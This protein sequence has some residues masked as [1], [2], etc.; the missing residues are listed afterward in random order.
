MAEDKP[1]PNV[2]AKR[3]GINTYTVRSAGDAELR[4]GSPGEEGVFS[5]VELLQAAIAGCA[6]M[7]AEPQ[8]T[9]QLGKDFAATTTV[10]AVQDPED[11]RLDKLIT[12]ISTDMAGLD[13]E[14][15]D[16]LISRSEKFIEKLC[17]VKRTLQHGVE[18]ETS[19]R[20]GH[21]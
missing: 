2:T 14:K 18:T 10:E 20:D 1:I 8:L 16:K 5:P 11:N 9:S 6:A 21:S 13:P 17:T 4:I 3:S 15:R 12:T 7:S 19:V